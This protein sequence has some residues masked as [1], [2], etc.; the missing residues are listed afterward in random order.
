MN[1]TRPRTTPFSVTAYATRIQ[2]TVKA[3]GSAVVEGEVQKPR[4]TAGGA[5][6]FDFTDGD[7]T[8]KAKVLPWTLRDGIAHEPSDGELVRLSVSQ[9]DFWPK[10]GILT[11]V[12][13][14]IELAGD[15]E[16]LKR[17][18]DLIARLREEGLTNEVS[19]PAL[20]KFPMTIGLIAGAASSGLEDVLRALKDRF[21]AAR[22]I[23]ACCQVQGAGAPRAVIDALARLDLDP[24]VE[25]IIVSRGGGS[26][27]D[28]IAF[29]DEGLCRAMSALRTPVVAAI[30]HTDNVPV[31][32][33]VTHSALT[34]SRVAELVVPDRRVLLAEVDDA[35][36]A[37]RRAIRGWRQRHEDLDAHTQALRGIARIR[38]LQ[39]D[40]TDAGR[41]VDGA[42]TQFISAATAV[43]VVA[44]EQLTLAPAR[45]RASLVS[46]EQAVNEFAEASMRAVEHPEHLR[47][48]V[49]QLA[50]RLAGSTAR[51]MR[52]RK[53]NWFRALDRQ[54]EMLGTASRRFLEATALEIQ[55]DGQELG[56]GASRRLQ[57]IR[58]HAA[59]LVAVL[60]AS[61]F[62]DRGWLLATAQDGR[63]ITSVAQVVVGNRLRLHLQDGE[64]DAVTETIQCD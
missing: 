17:R 32:N 12:V 44:R 59:A 46:R 50:E 47:A 26:P 64:I 40:V 4:K 9:P 34:P 1:E 43:A 38:A 54:G 6:M 41:V 11:I 36:A 53:T 31:C 19:F 13:E 20:P 42:A 35:E 15:G 49:L 55:R 57:A 8:L 16:L 28:L 51:I 5:L 14:E 61:D 48:D 39:G 21:P 22:A 7:S 3:V 2:R 33:F 60:Q 30:G 63:M 52:E 45:L 27:R 25:V 29:D 58:R 10:T 56:G 18:R 24:A 37:G 23:T 62:R